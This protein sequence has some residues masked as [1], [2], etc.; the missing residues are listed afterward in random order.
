MFNCAYACIADYEEHLAHK[1]Q[2]MHRAAVEEFR[3]GPGVSRGWRTGTATYPPPPELSVPSN[4]CAHP[5]TCPR[6]KDLSPTLL[7]ADLSLATF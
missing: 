4:L 6:P 7:P 3:P 2:Q 1:V 5:L